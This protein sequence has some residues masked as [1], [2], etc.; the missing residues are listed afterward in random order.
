MVLQ[1][2]EGDTP[3]FG[4]GIRGSYP[5]LK[6]LLEDVQRDGIDTTVAVATVRFFCRSPDGVPRFPVVVD[7]HLNGRKD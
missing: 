3:T 5:N 4:A 7:Y 2:D 6:Q 1:N